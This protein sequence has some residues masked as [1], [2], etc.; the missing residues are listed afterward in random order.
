M[1]GR[2]RS[3]VAQREPFS[4]SRALLETATTLTNKKGTMR[5]G[6][7]VLYAMQNSAAAM[8]Q[9]LAS[10]VSAFRNIAR[11]QAQGFTYADREIRS[12]MADVRAFGEALSQLGA[13][14]AGGNR[15]GAFRFHTLFAG[16][17]GRPA[18]FGARTPAPYS[19]SFAQGTP[20]KP[21]TPHGTQANFPNA[22]SWASYAPP[23]RPTPPAPTIPGFT[24][25]Q[26]D[27][28]KKTLK[29]LKLDPTDLYRLH[30][31]GTWQAAKKALHDI[32]R[33]CHPDKLMD[34]SAAAQLQGK[35][36]TQLINER[37]AQLV[38]VREALIKMH[39]ASTGN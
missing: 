15:Q 22:R 25:A 2:I 39:G 13:S 21:W 9:K 31:D 4:N 11:L 12:A 17:N 24:I 1:A 10:A 35:E 5:L 3:H 8:P 18:D 14:N 38:Q 28:M 29:S 36:L 6:F 20:F 33:E 19:F 30:Q 27:Q 23:T 34:R 32:L 37:K 7:N 16:G 26:C